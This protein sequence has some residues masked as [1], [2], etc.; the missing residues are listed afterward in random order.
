MKIHTETLFR[1]FRFGPT[2]LWNRIVMAPMTRSRCPEGVPTPEVRD[3][4]QRRAE[5]GVGLIV[6]EGTVIDHPGASGYPAVPRMFGDDALDGWKPIIEAA[7]SAGAAIIPQLWH[8]GSVRQR[9]MEP[10]P[11]IPGFGPSPVVHPS[12][13]ENGEAPEEL[14][15][16]DILE[17]IGAFADAAANARSIG[18]DGVEIHGAHGYLVDQF[19]WEKTNQRTDSWGGSLE[20][21]LRFPVEV[22]RA[23]RDA[24]GPDFPIVFRFSQWKSGDYR[25]RLARDPSELER[26]LTPLAEAG[27]DVFHASTRKYWKPEFRGSELN[28]AGWTRSVTGLPVITVGSVGLDGDF[29]GAFMGRGANPAGIEPLIERMER[30]EFDLVAVGR[31]LI[32]DAQWPLKVQKGHF[33]DVR[34]F[35]PEMLET[36]E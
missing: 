15:E 1:P 31:A 3:Y 34:P 8:V 11:E 7:H 33:E 27:V 18:F 5:G 19:M 22:V 36:L 14:D 35:T 23:V 6:T 30:E 25:A 10:D 29:L 24:T 17:I 26:L 13:G 28:L 12:L 4:Y 32:A 16:Q 9:G 21:R 20:N 2:T